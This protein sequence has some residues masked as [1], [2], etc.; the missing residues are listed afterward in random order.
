[1]SE[2]E[3]K[4]FKVKLKDGNEITVHARKKIKCFNGDVYYFCSDLRSTKCIEVLRSC[5]VYEINKLV[6]NENIVVCETKEGRCRPHKITLDRQNL[7]PVSCEVV[8][9]EP[10]PQP[11][12]DH[13]D[14]CPHCN[15]TAVIGYGEKAFLVVKCRGPHN[16]NVPARAMRQWH[17]DSNQ[18]SFGDS[19]CFEAM[20]LLACPQCR[21]V[22]MTWKYIE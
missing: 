4:S 1:M 9:G 10:T 15:Y 2:V 7:W 14:T 16:H 6:Y 21:K 11:E 22:F 18:D 5:D 19:E 20:A 8:E 13:K 3:Q 17:D 12:E